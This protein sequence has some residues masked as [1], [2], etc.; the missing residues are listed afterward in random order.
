NT[1]A[2]TLTG[3]AGND[4]L[5]GGA[6]NDTL[7]GG[8]GNDIYV[9]ENTGD[10]VTENASEGTDLV[11]SSV[12]ITLLANVENLTLT[13]GAA[14][15]GT[16]NGSDNVIAGNTAVNT[17]TGG[18]GNDT[19][20]GGGGADTLIGGTGNDIYVVD[21]TSDVI[22]ENAAE[23]TDLV[24]SSVTFVLAANVE[25][26][27]LTG[28]ISVNGTGNSLANT[29]TGN[30]GDNTLNGGSGADTL[31]GGAG[32][33]TYVIDNT[34][35]VITEGGSDTSDTVLSSLVDTTLGSNLENL[36]LTRADWEVNGT[37]NSLNNT[38][39]GQENNNI[40]TG[41][42]GNDTLDGK[43]G[44][45][46]LVGGTDDDTYYVDSWDDVVVENAGEGIDT[47]I[48][49][50]THALA[51]NVEN[52]TLT[53][54]A[55]EAD[56]N[57]L[58]NKIIGSAVDNYIWGDDGDDDLN[59]GAGNDLV[60]GGKGA[61]TYR[62]DRGGGTDTLGVWD[63]DGSADKLIFGANVATDQLWFRTINNDAG[64]TANDLEVS[65]IGTTDK[66]YLNDWFASS[67]DQVERVQAAGKYAQASDVQALVNAM[68]SFSPPPL[69]QTTL[70]S[71]RANAL[72]AT[73]AASWH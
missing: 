72:A 55:D 5:D 15:N 44:D 39:I 27:T 12:T 33:D 52:V 37:G 42:A 6:G 18:A 21:N 59:G 71:T 45:D 10:V 60:Q 73:L 50:V 24:Q 11:Q 2:N 8:S 68:S 14:I 23:G 57:A 66:I 69:G 51:A 64:A 13:G 20:D 43:S 28:T 54:T 48:S 1:G 25:N 32:N 38:I 46:R 17:L 7:I 41:G 31:I 29:L 58:N 65:I 56:G 4:T 26:L 36:T 62:F 40:L 49:S 47:V 34:S 30:S 53:G 35:D 63:S 22:T 70:D 3:G 19:L 9:V 61:D 16:G 67:A